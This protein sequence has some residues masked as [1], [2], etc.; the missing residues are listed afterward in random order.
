MGKN[1]GKKV[2]YSIVTYRIRLYD[3]HFA[4]LLATR[5]LYTEVVEHFFHVLELETGLLEQSDFLLLRALEAKCI[6]TKEM[7]AAGQKPEYPLENFPKIP[8]YFRRSAINAAIT[9]IR[10]MLRNPKN[11]EEMHVEESLQTES[12]FYQMEAKKKKAIQNCPMILYKGMY[13]N[14]TD[15]S[16]D[17]KLF[18]NGK[19]IWVTYPYVGRKIPK[20]V[21]RLSPILSLEQKNAWLEVPVSFEVEDIR[22]VM[23]RLETEDRFC[24]VSFPDQDVLA[25]A[26][27]FSKDFIE[28]GKRFFHGG[29]QKE[30][31]RQQIL[32][33]LQISKESRGKGQKEKTSV[34]TLE[35]QEVLDKK[36]S[37]KENAR[38]YQALQE[39]N[40]YYAHMISKQ[41]LEYCVKENIKLIVVPN[42]ES[43]I[44][45]RDKKYLKTDAYRWLGRAII[46]KLK[47][48]AFCHGIV[49]T[50]VPP[51][52]I[53]DCCSECGAN[54]RKY[55]EGYRAGVQYYGGKLFVCPNGHKGNTAWNTARNVGKKFLSYYKENS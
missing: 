19:W 6:G 32:E 15:H 37:N 50:S 12:V 44:D 34:Q 42:Y 39:I 9:L 13:E 48:K 25:T 16:I 4:W 18:H 46:R 45:F 33:Q 10:K 38:L 14:F 7:K 49:V 30:Y 53:A 51:H 8:L 41:I 20:G 5:K 54:I 11:Q 3:R 26:V 31:R 43:S 21:Q 47:Y 24:A 29:K 27:I 40:Q 2:G 35:V 52:H 22:T 17:L 23:E 28:Q 55:N 36:I 1:D